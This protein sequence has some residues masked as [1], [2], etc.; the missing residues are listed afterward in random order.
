FLRTGPGTAADGLPKFDISK[1]DQSYFD[2]LRARVIEAGNH[3]IYTSV[4]L[5][6]P[7][8]VYNTANFT[9]SMYNNPANNINS[10]LSTITNTNQY[11]MANSTWVAY[12]DAYADK[13]VDTLNDLDNVLYE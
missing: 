1:F 3:G 9:Y 7:V 2:R 4:M 6:C 5:T 8:L 12:M 10:A 11:T 13:V